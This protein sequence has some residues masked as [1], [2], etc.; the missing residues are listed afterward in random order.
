[1]TSIKS[2]PYLI[3][4]VQL[5]I[6]AITWHAELNEA[7]IIYSY[8]KVINRARENKFRMQT[9]TVRKNEL[10][11]ESNKTMETRNFNKTKR[12]YT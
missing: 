2:N 7:T 11:E 6:F 9:Q 1:M 10:L 3:Q 4:Y 8:S 12:Q 5:K